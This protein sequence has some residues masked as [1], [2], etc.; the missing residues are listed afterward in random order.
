M[1]G[2]MFPDTKLIQNRAQAM[3]PS[4]HCTLQELRFAVELENAV[5]PEAKEVSG[6]RDGGCDDRGWPRG[7]CKAMKLCKR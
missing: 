1:R 5:Y 7:W 2:L 6:P 3:G 4:C